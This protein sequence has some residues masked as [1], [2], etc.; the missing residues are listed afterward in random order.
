[1]KRT[2]SGKTK[3]DWSHANAMNE[4]ERHAEAMVDPD[5]H[6]MTDEEWSFARRVP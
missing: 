1:M 6:P 4:S 3:I 2:A 5:A